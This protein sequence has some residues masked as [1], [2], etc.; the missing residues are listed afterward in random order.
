MPKAVQM[1]CL[2]Y[3]N[4]YNKFMQRKG[5]LILRGLS[6]RPKNNKDTFFYRILGFY[7]QLRATKSHKRF[8]AHISQKYN[9]KFDIA[10]DT[11]E[12]NLEN[13]IIKILYDKIKYV[14]INNFYDSYQIEG[15]KRILSELQ[16]QILQ[17]D[18]VIIMR[19]DIE[20]FRNFDQIFNPYE[21]KVMLPFVHEHFG[22]KVYGYS[23][24]PIVCDAF[25]YVPSNYYNFMNVFYNIKPPIAHMH[26]IIHIAKEDMKLEF[27][28][29]VYVN[30]YHN[31]DSLGDWNPLYKIC[32]K[33]HARRKKD[34][35]LRYP[36]HF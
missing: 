9:I 3:L 31:T 8:A 22:R 35:G 2:F 32:Y 34:N 26:D 19:N 33:K 17:Y 18:F 7:S 13:N 5:L 15:I 12:S 6:F 36:D 29:G 27:D 10:L 23:Q 16:S 1:N 28:F 20:I 11:T 25:I 21:K 4:K 24:W 30:T 14:K